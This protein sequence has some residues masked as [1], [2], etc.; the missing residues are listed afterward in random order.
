MQTGTAPVEVSVENPPKTENYL[1]Q[2]PA[3][4]LLGIYPKNTTS[5]YK[6]TCSSMFTAVRLIIVNNYKKSYLNLN[7]YSFEL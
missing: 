7:S 2:D 6:D 1:P 4:A 5:Y 3:I